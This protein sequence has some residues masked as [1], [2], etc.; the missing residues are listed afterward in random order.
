MT[1]RERFVNVLNYQPA[2]RC[3]TSGES[4]SS[5]RRSTMILVSS[6]R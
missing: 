4:R 5:A 1:D 2:D 6:K 3:V